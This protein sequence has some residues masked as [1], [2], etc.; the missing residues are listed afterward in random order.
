MEMTA[1]ILGPGLY[2]LKVGAN[3][4]G[5]GRNSE[6]ADGTGGGGVPVGLEAER[7]TQECTP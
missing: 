2:R 4:F 3:A 1:P 7:H 5:W 6:E